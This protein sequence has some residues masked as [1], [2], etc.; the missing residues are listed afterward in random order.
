MGILTYQDATKSYKE[1]LH[2]LVVV[3]IAVFVLWIRYG[4]LV[5]VYP[6]VYV[7]KPYSDPF[8][9]STCGTVWR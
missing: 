8:S 4:C 1:A 9:S 6:V 3:V 7:K 5:W 2:F